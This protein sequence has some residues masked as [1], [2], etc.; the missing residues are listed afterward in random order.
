MVDINHSWYG[1]KHKSE[2]IAK[3]RFIAKKRFSIP[4]NNPMF[5]KRHSEFSRRKISV[6]RKMRIKLGLIKII[7]PFKGKKLSPEHKAK[8]SAGLIGDKNPMFGV[9]R[10]GK[11][12][13]FYGRKHSTRTREKLSVLARI[14]NT[15]ERNPM[16]GKHHSKNTVEKIR[17]KAIGRRVS[18]ETKIK[19]SLVRAGR[20]RPEMCGKLAGD[21]NPNWHGGKSFEPYGIAFT[22]SLRR[23]VRN[24]FG[25]HCFLCSDGETTRKLCVHH[26]DY[27]KDNNNL[28]NL[29]P[30]CLKCHTKTNTCREYWQETL[31]NLMGGLL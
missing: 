21:K 12:H 5:G 4:E 14:K 24:R 27:K 22:V 13:P 1:K 6:T 23:D 2:T 28:V 11:S 18:K 25:N 29:L 31:T 9:H 19:M 30:L 15:G 26:I 3:L 7:P 17:I 20:P 16:F 10:H 8:I